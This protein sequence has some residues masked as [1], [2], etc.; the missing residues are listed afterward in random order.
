MSTVV[1]KDVKALDAEVEEAREAV[2][3]RSAA[4][5]AALEAR[6]AGEN[7]QYRRR[8]S[9]VVG[10][11]VKALDAEVEEA[12]EAVA[13]RSAAEKAALE[14]K[15][16]GENQ[17][18]RRR[19]S[20][21]V[22]K[23]VKAL[24]AEV[25][26]AR[27]AVAERSAAE[28]AAL[29]AKLA[30]EN[31]QYRRRMSTVVGKD[32]KALDAEVEEAREAVAERS[33]A[34]K[35][36]LEAKLAEENQQPAAEKAALERLA[37]G[38]E[39]AVTGG[40]HVDLQGKDVKAL[41]R[42]V[43][44]AREAVA[45][46][47]GGGEGGAGA[48]LA[49]E[50]AAQAAHATEAKLA[51][52]NQQYRRRMSTVVGKDVKA[53]DAEVEE[54][55]EAVAE[56]SV[57][58]KAALEAKLAGENQQY[59]RRMSTVVGKDVKALDAEVEE[60]REAVAER[61]AAE[62]A[63]QGAKLAGENQQYRRRMS[64]VVGKDVKALDAEVEEARE[65]VAERSAAE[66][67]AL[68]AK[69]AE[70]NQQYRRRMS[71][72]VGKDVKALDA[73]V[74]EAREAVAERSAAE[75]A[76]LEAKLAEENQQY[77]RRMSTV[78]GKDVKALDAEVEEAREAVAERSAAEKAA[79]EAKLAEENQQYR[80][81]MSTVV[82]KDVKA[83]DAEVEEAREAVAERSVAQ[84]AALEAKLAGE[85]QQYRR[86]MSTVVG[87]DVKALDAEV[88][89]ARAAVAWR[90]A[91]KKAAQEAKLAE[92]NQQYRRRM[93]TVVEIAD[94]NLINGRQSIHARKK[95]SEIDFALQAARE[96]AIRSI[97]AERP[98]SGAP[99]SP[100]ESRAQVSRLRASLMTKPREDVEAT[101]RI[102]AEQKA[103]EKLD[104]EAQIAKENAAMK[105]R[106][107]AV[108][109]RATTA[110]RSTT[111]PPRVGAKR[112]QEERAEA[113]AL[114]PAASKGAPGARQALS[115]TAGER[116]PPTRP[117]GPRAITPGPRLQ[118]GSPKM[119]GGKASS[120]ATAAARNAVAERIA[121]IKAEAE[122]KRMEA[123]LAMKRRME[124]AEKLK[125]QAKEAK[126]KQAKQLTKKVLP[127]PSQAETSTAA[128]LAGM[129]RIRRTEAGIAGIPASSPSPKTQVASS[130]SPKTQ[131]AAS[132]SPKTQV[133]P[134]KLAASPKGHTTISVVVA[135]HE[136][137]GAAK[138]SAARNEI[139]ER[140][141][142][143]KLA[144]K[145]EK[146]HV[147]SVAQLQR[148]LDTY[149]AQE[150]QVSPR[151]HTTIG[152]AVGLH[153]AAGRAKLAVEQR[154]VHERMKAKMAEKAEK[155]HMTSEA[156]LQRSLEAYAA[157][158]QRT[159]S[160]ISKL[161]IAGPST[162][163]GARSELGP[164][165]DEAQ[166]RGGVSQGEASRSPIGGTNGA[167][168][169]SERFS[170]TWYNSEF[171]ELPEIP[172]EAAARGHEGGGDAATP[173]KSSDDAEGAAEGRRSLASTP[174]RFSNVHEMSPRSL[175][176]PRSQSSDLFMDARSESRAGSTDDEDIFEDAAADIFS[177]SEDE[178][179]GGPSENTIKSRIVK[180]IRARQSSTPWSAK[181]AASL[182]AFMKPWTISKPQFSGGQTSGEDPQSGAE[183]QN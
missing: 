111:A 40:A 47:S 108:S 180:D 36:A 81:R 134:L 38:G 169:E 61:S 149:S 67:A 35:A 27:E 146:E 48:K 70:E 49:G 25:E 115:S 103:K 86:R 14:A 154:G 140:M 12:R 152:M 179:E 143:R 157:V 69:L 72:V 124:A 106:M 8:M 100:D 109:S 44:E 132:S 171:E 28:K 65:A 74:E 172:Q 175:M 56:R 5:K 117:A 97:A 162:D 120:Q 92:E 155:G 177:E 127:N 102:K 76:A 9:T 60:A 18:Y 95:S 78:V 23:D 105:R 11:D 6:L 83:L 136:A 178:K 114:R 22:G 91:A 101:R 133:P 52:E 123:D 116:T 147:T 164:G 129:A 88:E 54:A 112:L 73:E 98:A 107:N 125:Q 59:R 135:L 142:A 19:M 163:G 75:K 50:P 104:R 32:V 71:T 24:D 148:S 66:K 87:K 10:K 130:P 20:T 183:A 42:E 64:T 57:A 62:K 176:S 159:Q 141:K 122:Q 93:S 79:L 1:G 26:E 137:G 118:G 165:S 77:R 37:G 173:R 182:E 4:E 84:K 167:G 94:V 153:Q 138:L 46:R 16:A 2:A 150:T 170:V 144:E 13:E 110:A 128:R 30:G 131:V 151:G 90:V 166:P 55:R 156:Q 51:E 29:E 15:L 39:P 126:V 82:G 63:A 85:N 80:R 45:E 58:Q 161:E 31:Q 99:L 174:R 119:A 113:R 3:E 89:E 34:E 68:E 17:Q 7:Q 121:R 145:A 41:L 43:E 158:Q 96:D 21:V 160:S 33:A 168:A 181:E 139:H 53:L